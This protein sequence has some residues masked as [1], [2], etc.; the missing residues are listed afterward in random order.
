MNGW[1]HGG[2]LEEQPVLFPPSQLFSPS[3]A[4][5]IIA[6]AEPHKVEGYY[7]KIIG[8]PK[9]QYCFELEKLF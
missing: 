4:L 3:S 5:N 1:N 8:N 9:M 2:L 6:N 7:L